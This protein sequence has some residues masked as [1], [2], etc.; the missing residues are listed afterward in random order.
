[1][2]DG[3]QVPAH[4]LVHEADALLLAEL[5]LHVVG[6]QRDEEVVRHQRF[7]LHVE[8]LAEVDVL[9]VERIPEVVVGRGDDLVE[10]RGAVGVAVDLEHRLKI[11]GRHR[12]VHGVLGDVA[13]GHQLFAPL[14]G[15]TAAMMQA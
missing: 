1:M 11:V 10:G 13:V 9:G 5:R 14:P 15:R 4:Q 8:R 12:V 6:L 2:Q 3:G 7:V